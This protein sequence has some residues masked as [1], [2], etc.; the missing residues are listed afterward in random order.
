MYSRKY[1]NFDH[2]EILHRNEMYFG[3]VFNVTTLHRNQM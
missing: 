2:N 3:Y 1:T